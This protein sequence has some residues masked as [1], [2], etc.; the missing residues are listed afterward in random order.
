MLG[1]KDSSIAWQE[2]AAYWELRHIR[3]RLCRFPEVWILR[4]VWWLAI[5]GKIATVKLS[6]KSTYVAYL[7]FQTTKDCKELDLPANSSISFGGKKRETEN[8]Y[9]ERPKANETWQ[10]NYVFP[11]RREDGWMEIKLGEIEYKEG[12]DG[13]VDMAFVEVTAN[14]KS[15]LIM[16]VVEV[17]KCGKKID[18]PNKT[19]E[20]PSRL[21]SLLIELAVYF[22]LRLV[23]MWRRLMEEYFGFASSTIM[24]QKVVYE[25]W[26]CVGEID[27][28]DI[29]DVKVVEN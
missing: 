6:E 5:H 23:E 7:V 27:I 18:P 22:Y 17:C 15:G 20:L 26:K 24:P 8:V 12:D 4:K 14:Q 21:V 3:C 19:S 2:T 10:E 13:E 11:H 16:I 25:Y 1:P 9:L 28:K 29:K